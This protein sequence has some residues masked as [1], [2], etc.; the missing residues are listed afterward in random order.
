MGFIIIVIVILYYRNTT[1][2]AFET[3]ASL[4]LSVAP[5]GFLES[6]CTSDGT[7]TSCIWLLWTWRCYSLKNILSS[8]PYSNKISITLTFWNIVLYWIY[9]KIFSYLLSILWNNHQNKL[10]YKLLCLDKIYFFFKKY[11]V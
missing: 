1:Y 11:L 4:F 2:R 9:N 3:I 7:L 10:Y 6:L 5:G 8:E